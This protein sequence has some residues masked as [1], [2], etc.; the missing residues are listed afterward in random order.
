MHDGG[1]KVINTLSSGVALAKSMMNGYWVLNCRTV[2]HSIFGWPLK[3]DLLKFLGRFFFVWPASSFFP[4]GFDAPSAQIL[5]TTPLLF[6]NV[7]F[8]P[9]LFFRAWEGVILG[10]CNS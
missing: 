9:F 2:K 8:S 7:F 5:L 6:T 3:M 4:L 1:D 10:L